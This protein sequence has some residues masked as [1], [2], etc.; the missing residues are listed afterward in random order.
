MRM[1][2]TRVMKTLERGCRQA[3]RMPMYSNSS[4]GS[5]LAHVR[6]S[7]NVTSV[8]FWVSW[9]H[10]GLSWVLVAQGTNAKPYGQTI[11]TCPAMNCPKPGGKVNVEMR[12][13]TKAGNS[14]RL[15]GWHGGGDIGA[16]PSLP[17]HRGQLL[18]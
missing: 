16:I 9:G 6:L 11:A 2:T 10:M 8:S 12:S 5:C 18:P 3:S 13:V 15:A 1:K 7:N 17:S 14:R 4:L